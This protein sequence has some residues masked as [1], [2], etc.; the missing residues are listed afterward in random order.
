MSINEFAV[1]VLPVHAGQRNV[2]ELA[3]D[4]SACKQQP[5]QGIDQLCRCTSFSR[6][7]LQHFYRLFKQARLH[8]VRRSSRMNTTRFSSSNAWTTQL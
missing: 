3:S 2:S 1:L 6:K 8:D 4:S 7:Q 5:V